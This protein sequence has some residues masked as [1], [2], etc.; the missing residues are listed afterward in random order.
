M[1]N[2]TDVAC[3]K[4]LLDAAKGS[5]GAGQKPGLVTVKPSLEVALQ[6]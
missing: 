3:L 2:L 4:V 5:S 1:A 6:A